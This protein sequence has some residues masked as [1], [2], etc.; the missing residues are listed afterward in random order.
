MSVLIVPRKNVPE[1]TSVS[2]KPQSKH[3]TPAANLQIPPINKPIRSNPASGSSSEMNGP[4][5]PEMKERLTAL[6]TRQPAINVSESGAQGDVQIAKY[7]TPASATLPYPGLDGHPIRI[8]PI[9]DSVTMRPPAVTSIERLE[10]EKKQ[11]E[12]LAKELAD[13]KVYQRDDFAGF[14]GMG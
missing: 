5:I 11:Q 4:S 1:V 12:K 3:P 14:S 8:T 7:Y 9:P 10:D 2:E 13:K 6:K